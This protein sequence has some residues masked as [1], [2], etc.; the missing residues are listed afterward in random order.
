MDGV[1]V[2]MNLEDIVKRYKDKIVSPGGEVYLNLTDGLDFIGQCEKYNIPIWGI[3]VVKVTKEGVLSPL[4][5]TIVYDDQIDVYSSAKAFVE[6]QMDE[7]W[8]YAI[9]VVG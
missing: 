2:N 3:D 5:K 8:N 7:V 6:S 1:L 9:F 4:D